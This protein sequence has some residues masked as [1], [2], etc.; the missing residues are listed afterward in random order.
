VDISDLIN[1]TSKK[2]DF[3][4]RIK[5]LKVFVIENI[6]LKKDDYFISRDSNL[7]AKYILLGIGTILLV[8]IYRIFTL[9]IL[10]YER[11]DKLS[12]RNY[13]RSEIIYPNRGLIYDRKSKILV[14][15]V[16]KYVLNQN[17][18]KCLV[19]KNKD[20]GNCLEQ[21]QKLSKHIEIDVEK[22]KERYSKN[23]IINI[24]RELSKD[25]AILV[26]S[27]K[28]I[29]SIEVSILPQREYSFNE[30]MSHV[31]GFVGQSETKIGEYEGKMGIEKQYEDF[32]SGI[33]GS[34]IYKSDSLNS[35]LENYRQIS[36]VAGK[37]IKLAID[38]KMQNFTYEILM[39]KISSMPS[40][41]G[42]AVVV[43]DPRNGD[44]LTLVNYPSFDVNK[45]SKGMSEK[46]YQELIT[47]NSF[48]FLN[49][50]ISGVY[51]PGSVFKV[52]TASGILEE[53]IA[54]PEDKIFDEGFIK[55]GESVY[56]NWKRDGHGVVDY[57]RS[58]KVSNDTYYYIYSGGYKIPKGLGITGI[59]NWSKKYK[60]GE[61]QGIDLPGE[62]SG[63]I[64]DGRYKTWY[65]GDTFI[66]AIGQG[67]VLA[68]PLQMSVLMSYFANNQKVYAPRVVLEA[69]NLV[70]KEKILYENLLSFNT[71]DVIKDS[72]REVNLPGGTAVPF[73]EFKNKHGF[74][75]AGKTGT[76][77]YFDA[78]YQKILTHAW[79]SGF[80][81]YNQGEI[82]VTVFI[83]SGG[84]GSSDAAPIARQVI[85]F[86]FENKNNN[87]E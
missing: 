40:A 58:M 70:K 17:I 78:R 31:L 34:N 67:D 3:R 81:P 75:S 13:L 65:L 51:P 45:M 19:T 32:L 37:D 42:G 77:E 41:V 1:S 53:G 39:K 66:S 47:N 62:S 76:S 16:P 38:S 10:E 15:N 68:T 48:P 5:T 27:L 18:N 60:L 20:F 46:E 44:V 36:P 9:Q 56:G 55:I 63:F 50:A 69:D 8:Y 87:Q 11:F 72:L 28:D 74:E 23:E 73:F 79:Y 52:V 84:A 57:K 29:P 80:A 35:K 61:L 82:V 83:E 26:G 59:Y 85:D 21:I 64:P 30:S 43:Q 49:R 6:N 24:K 86:Y 54:K 33:A 22:V 14:K 71:F 2:L 7:L 12:Q 25:E 4:K